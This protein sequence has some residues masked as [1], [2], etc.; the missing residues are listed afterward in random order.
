[1][2]PLLPMSWIGN[3]SGVS[4]K[5]P[6]RLALKA[7]KFPKLGVPNP[8]VALPVQVPNDPQLVSKLPKGLVAPNPD[9]VVAFTTR[10]LLSPYCAAGDPVISSIPCRALRGICVEKSLL[11]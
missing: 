6:E 4:R 2:L 10:L 11:C 3:N 5:R 1:M 9:L 7:R 8:S